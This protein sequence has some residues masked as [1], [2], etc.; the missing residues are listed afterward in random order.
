MLPPPAPQLDWLPGAIA[1]VEDL[2][3]LERAL[4]GTSKSLI[5]RPHF[6]KD[7]GLEFDTR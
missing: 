4:V 1:E 3:R 5:K 6:I 7:L 2:M